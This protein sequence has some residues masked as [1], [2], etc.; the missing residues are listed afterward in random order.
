MSARMMS[1]RNG[2]V[3]VSG[4]L[5]VVVESASGSDLGAGCARDMGHAGPGAHGFC[6]HPA[7]CCCGNRSYH[8]AENDEGKSHGLG[9]EGSKGDESP[10]YSPGSPHGCSGSLGWSSSCHGCGMG[11]ETWS[12]SGIWS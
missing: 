8:H 10:G 12:G 6:S 7:S 3:N 4:C 2:S 5:S 9:P 1:G 11:N